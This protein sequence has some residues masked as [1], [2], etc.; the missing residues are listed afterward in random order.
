MTNTSTIPNTGYRL[1]RINKT[2]KKL[3][4]KKQWIAKVLG[5]DK[6]ILYKI[7]NQKRTPR[8]IEQ[9]VQKMETLLNALDHHLTINNAYKKRK[10]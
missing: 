10:K 8:D 7:L 6:S 2:I 4:V 5:I 3:D 9:M 1:K